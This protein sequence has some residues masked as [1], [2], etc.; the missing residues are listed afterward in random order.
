LK[1]GL[2][3]ELAE[4]GAVIATNIWFWVGFI[5]F[6]LAMLLNDTGWGE[7]LPRRLDR[8]IHAGTIQ[9]MIAV[10]PDCFTKYGGSMSAAPNFAYDA[11]VE[12]ITEEERASIDLSRW[13]VAMNGAEP[14]RRDTI[15]R[16][17]AAS[18]LAWPR[19]AIIRL[20]F[21]MLCGPFSRSSASR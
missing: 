3:H 16:F 21:S 15:A 17:I 4:V 6:V 18:R 10:M 7:T 2:V 19:A 9:P 8:L 1:L 12:R 20:A 14:V 11:C 13:R 5:A